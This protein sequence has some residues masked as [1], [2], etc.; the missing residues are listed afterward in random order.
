MRFLRGRPKNIELPK[1]Y[2]QIQLIVPATGIGSRFKKQGI[3]TSKPL[4]APN[5]ES[6]LSHVFSMYPEVKDPL[7]ILNKDDKQI[8]EILLEINKLKPDSQIVKISQHKLG[9]SYT[10]WEARNYINLQKKIIVNYID[11]YACWNWHDMYDQLSN[12][13]GSILT[14]T[15]NHPHM[16]RNTKY[17]YVKLKANTLISDIKEKESFTTSPMFENASAGVYGYKTGAIL[18]DALKYQISNNLTVNGEFYNSLSFKYL[19]EEKMKVG[20]INAQHFFQWGTP[21]DLLDWQNFFH[22][23]YKIRNTNK[24]SSNKKIEGAAIILAAGE[25]SRLN[26]VTSTPKPLTKILWER[27]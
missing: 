23:F 2:S 16:L 4:I 25:G 12:N 3:S 9:P 1:M 21:E 17:A 7:I 13:E 15:G 14:Y 6:F 11:F 19:L 10:I 22:L 27:D 8:N 18:L 5:G 20:N 26:N 24:K